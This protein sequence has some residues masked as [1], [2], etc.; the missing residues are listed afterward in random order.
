MRTSLILF[1]LLAA[2]ASKSPA[3]ASIPTDDPSDDAQMDAADAGMS[4]VVAPALISEQGFKELHE[5]R[6]DA[7][8]AA[9]R[10]EMIALPDGSRAYRS[11]PPEHEVGDPAVIVIHEWWGL[12]RHI[13][14]WADRLAADGYATIAVDLYGGGVA[15][16]RDQAMGLMK[17]VDSAAA[18]ET[19]SAAYAELAG[20][21]LQADK[22]G[23]I[24]WCFGG[25]WALQ[26]A[27]AQPELDAA[28][29]Y[30][31]RLV[32][33][34]DQLSKIEAP[35][36]GIFGTQDEGIPADAVRAFSETLES[37]DKTVLIKLYDAQHAF[38]NPSG[39]HYD[40][41]HARDAWKTAQGFLAANLKDD[42]VTVPVQP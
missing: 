33:D 22:I 4:P 35:L 42:T 27:I 11:L 41:A 39:A 16:T 31:G 37:M 8:A 12:N 14:H 24:G 30:Y 26:T 10:G 1:S 34:R 6:T 3:D 19:L 18:E 21:G 28:V 23:V 40:E 20:P 25:G 17:S 38:A 5:L 13:K 36:L 2:C 9:P 29:V 7:P 15:E 32:D